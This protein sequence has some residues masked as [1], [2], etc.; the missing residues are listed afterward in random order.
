MEILKNH[1]LNLGFMQQI[2]QLE[3]P[4]EKLCKNENLWEIIIVTIPYKNG[5]DAIH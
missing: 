5:N 1:S 4:T 3:K 2:C